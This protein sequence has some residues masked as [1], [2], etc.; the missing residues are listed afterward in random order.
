MTEVEATNEAEA[1]SSTQEAKPKATR[2]PQTAHVAPKKGK[3]NRKPTQRKQAPKSA[4]K[5]PKAARREAKGARE[6]SKKA[7]ILELVRRKAG[8]TL[9]EL[10]KATGW[11]PNSIRGMISGQMGKKMNLKV[12]SNKREDGQRVYRLS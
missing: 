3:S 5:A 11:N 1:E 6:G 10:V 7:T 8:A 2:A 9:D 12:D 4:N